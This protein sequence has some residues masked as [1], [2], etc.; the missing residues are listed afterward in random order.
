MLLIIILRYNVV[1][2]IDVI[3]TTFSGRNYE[4][5]KLKA[6]Y[7][8]LSSVFLTLRHRFLRGE[9][10]VINA[11]YI[12]SRVTFSIKLFILNII[13]LNLACL[14]RGIY[15]YIDVF[16]LCTYFLLT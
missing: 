12:L 14:G 1:V 4:L 3:F 2:I 16:F 6:N 8:R 11:S 5:R 9:D 15:F 13:R 7:K 10:N